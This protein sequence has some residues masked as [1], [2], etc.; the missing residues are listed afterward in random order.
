M[1]HYWLLKAHVEATTIGSIILAGGLLKI[2][3]YGVY[4]LIVWFKYP[5]DYRLIL[6]GAILRGILCNFQSDFKKLI[7]IISVSHMRLGVSSLLCFITPSVKGFININIR[8]TISRR[9]LFYIRGVMISFTRRRSLYN[10]P[11]MLY[12]FIF[13]QYCIIILINLGVPPFLSF[14]AEIYRISSVLTKRYLNIVSLLLLLISV[15][16]YTIIL[17]RSFKK[18]KLKF[19]K[20][21][22]SINIFYLIALII[23]TLLAV[24]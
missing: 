4:T 19:F 10:F 24:Y 11:W 14:I 2:G 20:V 17:F 13:V 12:K 18:A 1:L 9:L 7:A 3:R 22:V 16:R 8:H 6:G 5:I 15:T 21:I 23:L